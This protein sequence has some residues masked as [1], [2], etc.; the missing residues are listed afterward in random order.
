MPK[1]A[2]ILLKNR[3]TPERWRLRPQT[4]LPPAAG[5]G[6]GLASPPWRNPW[7]R[8]CI[9]P[10]KSLVNDTCWFFYWKA[11]LIKRKEQTI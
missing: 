6:P 7:L 1:N 3:K 11:Y 8:A 9:W 10:T 4:S 5:G 2:L